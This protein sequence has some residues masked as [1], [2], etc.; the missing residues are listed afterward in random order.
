MSIIAKRL[1]DDDIASL[2]AWYASIECIVRSVNARP[3][4]APMPA[5]VMS[6]SVMPVPLLA[7]ADTA[8]SLEFRRV[9][10]EVPCNSA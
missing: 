7:K 3:R 6:D 8:R 10:R 2:A 5:P 9:A 1:S 4:G